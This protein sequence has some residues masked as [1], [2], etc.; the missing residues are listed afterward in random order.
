[1]KDSMK[2][3]NGKKLRKLRIKRK[4]SYGELATK[5]KAFW[6]QLHLE[7]M[8]HRDVVNQLREK[9][10]SE[11]LAFARPDFDLHAIARSVDDVQRYKIRARDGTLSA[12][13]A[14]QAA[15]H[16]E[17]SAIEHAFYS[18]VAAEPEDVRAELDALRRH[19]E[20]HLRRVD[21]KYRELTG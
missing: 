19:T 10:Q 17:R 4:W 11:E 20:D 8:A 18:V 16:L 9:I 15:A 5:L 2:K 3:F 21:E 6:H 1:M 7:E 12:V 13:H 14:L